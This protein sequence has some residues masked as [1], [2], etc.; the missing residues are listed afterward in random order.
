MAEP[1][2]TFRSSGGLQVY[3]WKNVSTKGDKPIEFHTVSFARGYKDKNNEWAS[4]T[5]LREQDIP[6]MKM[7][8]QKAFEFMVMRR[9][10]EHRN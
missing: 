8:L 4:T 1:V 7:L 5:N 2:K 3:V 10:D 9:D 6:K